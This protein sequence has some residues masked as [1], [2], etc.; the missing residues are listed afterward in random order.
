[1][2]FHILT[3]FPESIAPYFTSSI[4]G[5]AQEKGIVR[6]FLHQLRGYANDKHHSVDDRPYGFGPG[7]V[8][9]P[10]VLVRAVRELKQKEAIE[11][12]ILLSPR[13][14]LFWQTKAKALSALKSVLLVCGRY[15][16]VDQRAIDL[17]VDEEISI[18]DYVLSGGEPA[19]VVVVDALARLIPGVVGN[20]QAVVDES[21]SDG[22]LE[23]PHY[24]RPEEFEGQKVPKVLL[25]G[26]H[27]EI[28]KWRREE[29]LKITRKNRPDL[30][31]K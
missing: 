19:A 22:L 28:E 14:G 29:S 23:Y 12:V 6:I 10:D 18:G 24:T 31:K 20:E 4:L 7:M 5:R 26:N 8:L 27:A 25:S 13:G 1:M 9:R 3:L 2:D 15:E 30:L 11:R 21:H 17:V 16:G